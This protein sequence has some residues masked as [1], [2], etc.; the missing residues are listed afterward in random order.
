M[1]R[2][3]G[4]T[5]WLFPGA[6]LVLTAAM[7]LRVPDQDLA[8]SVVGTAVP[9]SFATAGA[10]IASRRPRNGIGWL[11]CV[12]ALTI[13]IEELAEAGIRATTT[14][15]PLLTWT[16]WATGW[17][18]APLLAAFVT[19][20]PVTFPNGRVRGRAAAVVVSLA[21]AGAALVVVGNALHPG[22]VGP[23][24]NP[25]QLSGHDALLETLTKIGIIPVA[26]AAVASIVILVH[27]YHRAVGA[28]RQQLKWLAFA[29]VV[30]VVSAVGNGILYETGNE[31]AGQII[32]GL[33]FF[34]LPVALGVAIL[35]H[36]LYDINRLVSR[37]VAYGLVS[38]AV[39]AVYLASVTALT[40][41]TSPMTSHS[42]ITVAAATLL[43]G[44][45]FQ[46]LRRRI[47]RAVDRRFNRA[48]YDAQRTV[49][50]YRGRLR[51]ELDLDAIADGLL[52]AARATLEPS[53]VVVWFQPQRRP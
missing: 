43:A 32:F 50:S 10:V 5:A 27:R 51:D 12:F 7:I 45:A 46:P 25:V 39:M 49:D 20:L 33:G 14:P 17:T 9:L 23:I 11:L 37:T 8:A 1:S 22:D 34:W 29:M 30:A 42:P 31:A 41:L 16:A 36:N 40:A 53:V 18:W 19:Y 38:A 13:P 2:R 47:Q 4:E 44:F 24:T 48:R 35:R 52:G 15:G 6:C 3:L 26:I 28:E 21:A